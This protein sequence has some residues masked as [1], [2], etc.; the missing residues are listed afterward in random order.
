MKQHSVTRLKYVGFRMHFFSNFRKKLTK[1]MKK[2]VQTW[3]GNDTYH[4]T[5]NSKRLKA[6]LSSTL[7]QQNTGTFAH[8]SVI[9]HTVVP[10]YQKET[11]SKTLCGHQNPGMLLYKI[12]YS[13]PSTSKNKEPVDTEGQLYVIK[14]Q[15]EHRNKYSWAGIKDFFLSS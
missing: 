6:I 14:R 10:W 8:K 11:G 1:I 9:I 4:I 2:K 13:Q 15:S 7:T 12:L 5:S 3:E